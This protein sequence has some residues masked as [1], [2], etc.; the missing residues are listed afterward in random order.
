V[1][2]KQNS[3]H[4]DCN[5]FGLMIQIICFSRG[6]LSNSGGPGARYRT[7]LAQA[8][9]ELKVWEDFWETCC[10][11]HAAAHLGFLVSVLRCS[12]HVVGRCS[13]CLGFS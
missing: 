13:D 1:L 6:K 8:R 12:E 7:K 5:E 11:G 2:E 10:I 4:Y 9:V 3:A